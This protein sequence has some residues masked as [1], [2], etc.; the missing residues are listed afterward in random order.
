VNCEAALSKIRGGEMKKGYFDFCDTCKD[1]IVLGR[2]IRCE[3]CMKK[4]NKMKCNHEEVASN[5]LYQNDE[6]KKADGF[7]LYCG[8]NFV[9]NPKQHKLVPQTRKVMVFK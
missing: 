6:L 1:E 8:I 7:C 4:T 3:A 2:F 5:W 9:Y